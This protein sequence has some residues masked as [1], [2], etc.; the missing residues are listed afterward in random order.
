MTV[1]APLPVGP[2][3]TI[4]ADPPWHYRDRVNAKNVR[5]AIEAGYGVALRGRKGAE[6]FY[7]TLPTDVICS[8]PVEAVADENAH[9]YLWTTNA[10]MKDALKVV[11]AWGFVQK[12]I[13]TWVKPGMG[14]GRY[15]RN[16]TE[17]VLFCV[18][19]SL[20]GRVHNLKTAFAAKKAR[21]SAK[22][23]IFYRDVE[24][25]SPGPYVELFA[26]TPRPG[27]TAWGNQVAA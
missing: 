19:G 14:M 23:A 12:T 1:F 10:H 27:W 24:L 7:Q 16:N 4:V 21:H 15:Y 3:T 13:R 8:L 9:L 17:H 20:P 6:G 5:A 26:R 2:F 11:E 25:M 22:P 18:R